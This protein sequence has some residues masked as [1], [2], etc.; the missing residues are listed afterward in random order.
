[1]SEDEAW[2]LLSILLLALVIFVL[3]FIVKN[4]DIST[5]LNFKLPKPW[6]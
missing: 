6:R 4:I 3:F 5:I 2:L 1:M